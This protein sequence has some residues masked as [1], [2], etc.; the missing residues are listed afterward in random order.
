MN[1]KSKKELLMDF[2]EFH[3]KENP[4]RREQTN[5]RDAEA[6]LRQQN[7]QQ[8]DVSSSSG[9][10]PHCCCGDTELVCALHPPFEYDS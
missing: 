7:L 4:Y 5:E 3:Y 10:S 1:I 2:L 9:K 6:Y 8:P